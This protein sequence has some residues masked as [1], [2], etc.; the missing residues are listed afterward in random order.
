M[1]LANL[2]NQLREAIA[3]RMFDA[4]MGVPPRDWSGEMLESAKRRA[5]QVRSSR[6]AAP[7]ESPARAA[8][9]PLPA[10][11][12]TYAHPALGDLIV[13]L[14]DGGLVLRFDGGQIGDLVSL[15]DHRFRVTWGGPDQFRGVVTFAARS[16]RPE[17]LT[18]E[19]PAATF[20]RK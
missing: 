11:V 10:Y 16:E 14:K 17:L 7:P 9:L 13:T 5:E 1:V 8:P 15:G 2:P 6:A 4:F 12:A 3:F 19:F 20:T 18:L